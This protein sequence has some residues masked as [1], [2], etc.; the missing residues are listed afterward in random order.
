[1]EWNDL[2]PNDELDLSVKVV[3]RV[4]ALQIRLDPKLLDKLKWKEKRV[5]IQV[6]M[7]PGKKRV[8]LVPASAGWDIHDKK[9]RGA[10]ISVRQLVSTGKYSR[11]CDAAIE[12]DALVISLPDDFELKNPTMVVKAK[13]LAAA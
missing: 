5:K 6:S 4:T 2:V 12:N 1:M 9:A 13:V 11:K 3:T 10:E 7:A 8:R